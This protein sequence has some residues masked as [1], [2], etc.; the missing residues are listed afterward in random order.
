[1]DDEVVLGNERRAT[2]V[3]DRRARIG[4]VDVEPAILRYRDSEGVGISRIEPARHGDGVQ[5]GGAPTSELDRV[6]A[7]VAV[8]EEARAVGIRNARVGQDLLKGHLPARA[9][10]R[11]GLKASP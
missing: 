5:V 7:S 2:V 1:M 4:S 9:R 3:E 10:L 11:V 6:H 8:G